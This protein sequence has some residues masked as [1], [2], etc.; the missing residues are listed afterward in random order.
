MLRELA[1][2]KVIKYMVIKC[3]EDAGKRG[4]TFTGSLTMLGSKKLMVQNVGLQKHSGNDILS[5]F[6]K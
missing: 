1:Q 3:W 2:A 5:P 6:Y 4:Q